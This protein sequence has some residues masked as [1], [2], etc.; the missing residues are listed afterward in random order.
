[1]FVFPL[2]VFGCG[3]FL[4]LI[5]NEAPTVFTQTPSTFNTVLIIIQHVREGAERIVRIKEGEVKGRHYTKHNT[6]IYSKHTL[7]TR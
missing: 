3:C 6:N 4:L 5:F 1:V 7:N 2:F